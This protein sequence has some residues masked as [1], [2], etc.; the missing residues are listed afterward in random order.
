MHILSSWPKDPLWAKLQEDL[1]RDGVMGRLIVL[2]LSFPIPQLV[3]PIFFLLYPFFVSFISFKPY[4]LLTSYMYE[5]SLTIHLCWKS[6]SI[7]PS[8]CKDFS[9]PKYYKETKLVHQVPPVYFSKTWLLIMELGYSFDFG[10]S[11]IS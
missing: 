5:V 9:S 6:I 2:V 3:S 10:S 11:S 7:T 1:G 4:K 8:H